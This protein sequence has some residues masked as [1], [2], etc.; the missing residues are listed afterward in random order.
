MVGTYRVPQ[1]AIRRAE[2]LM[3][4]TVTFTRSAANVP[5]VIDPVTLLATSSDDVVVATD[6]PCRRFSKMLPRKGTGGMS[7]GDFVVE[8]TTFAEVPLSA[9]ALQVNDFGTVTSSVEHPGEVGLR[10]RVVGL[11]QNTQSTKQRALIEAVIG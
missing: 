6:M 11:V 1:A 4:D 7:A 5:V 9:P 10:F 8:E 3:S 2:S